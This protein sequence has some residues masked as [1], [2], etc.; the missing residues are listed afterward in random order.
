MEVNTK[1]WSSEIC[2]L[3]ASPPSTRKIER[4]LV[5]RVSLRGMC[6]ALGARL[7]WLVGFLVTCF[8]TLPD[9][10]NVQ[11]IM[12]DHKVMIQRIEVEADAM[13]RFVQKKSNKK[14]VWLAMDAKS[15]KVIAFPVSDRCRTSF[16]TLWVAI[17]LAYRH[18]ATFGLVTP[19]GSQ[20][21]FPSSLA[22]FPSAFFVVFSS[23]FV[24]SC[25]ELYSCNVFSIR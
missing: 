4:L 9:H 15:R 18:K 17:P 10:L 1:R 3:G 2:V 6:R 5:E 16:K 22:F 25:F 8:E 19:R 13:A 21:S 11:P 12:C 20:I 7:K 23:R 14:W 24:S